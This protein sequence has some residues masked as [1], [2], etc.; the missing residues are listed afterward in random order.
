MVAGYLA[1]LKRADGSLSKDWA[2]AR[3]AW[4]TAR[5]V[6]KKHVADVRL[7]EDL[8]VAAHEA[9]EDVRRN[10]SIRLEWAAAQAQAQRVLPVVLRVLTVLA[11][12][13]SSG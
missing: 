11:E 8:T 7:P 4:A 1:H 2:M 3:L 9:L 12:T 5:D 10:D 13:P 6:L